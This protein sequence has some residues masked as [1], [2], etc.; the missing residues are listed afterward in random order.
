[1]QDGG[2]GMVLPL[3]T[4]D[5]KDAKNF[6][7]SLSVASS[8]A[9]LACNSSISMGK[10]KVILSSVLYVHDDIDYLEWSAS[11]PSV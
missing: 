1:M 10:D 11:L 8:S 4:D 3:F 2:I 5:I 9:V 6:R 7:F